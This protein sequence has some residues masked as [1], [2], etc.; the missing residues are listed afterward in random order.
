MRY[1]ACVAGRHACSF[2]HLP[3]ACL[4]LVDLA[5]PSVC[6]PVCCC[7]YRCVDWLVIFEKGKRNVRPA[8]IHS[9][10]FSF[11]LP[12]FRFFFRGMALFGTDGTID[13][14][15]VFRPLD[16]RVS[17][18]IIPFSDPYRH[19]LF[20][21]WCVFGWHVTSVDKVNFVESQA[22]GHHRARSKR[23]ITE[24]AS[25]LPVFP[26]IQRLNIRISFSSPFSV[27][28]PFHLSPPSPCC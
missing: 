18:M 17:P 11:L 21:S 25:L 4:L 5:L 10:S 16:Q 20:R 14:C 2:R 27:L 26:V 19:S 9:T 8:C 3:G 23:L 12:Y 24:H 6:L 15:K 7:C 1:D 28:C 13:D 22:F